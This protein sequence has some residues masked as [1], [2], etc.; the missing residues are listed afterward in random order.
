MAQRQTPT[1]A[2]SREFLL[3]HAELLGNDAPLRHYSRERLLGVE[4]RARFVEPDLA[5]LP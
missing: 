2:D 1:I 5:P 4:A 3:L